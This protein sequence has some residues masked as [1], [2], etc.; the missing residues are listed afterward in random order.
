[1]PKL[2]VL[3]SIPIPSAQ[4]TSGP[5]GTSETVAEGNRSGN[6]SRNQGALR[7]GCNQGALRT[8]YTTYSSCAD[9]HGPPLQ[10]TQK[11]HSAVQ[12]SANSPVDGSGGDCLRKSCQQN[13]QCN[14][15]SDRL[16][17]W[18][19][20]TTGTYLVEC[21]AMHSQVTCE[22]QRTLLLHI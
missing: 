14:R 3:R 9:T 1:M 15:W 12:A 4:C 8:G 6:R 11:L 10:A 20:Q 17:R 7:T 18:S 13:A 5:G 22:V 21:T 16:D 2:A 19:C